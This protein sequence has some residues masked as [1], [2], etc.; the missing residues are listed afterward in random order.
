[1]R[2]G[3]LVAVAE[4]RSGTM[5]VCGMSEEYQGFGNG[6]TDWKYNNTY[7]TCSIEDTSG[8][9]F[10]DGNGV[11]VTLTATSFETPRVYTGAVTYGAGNTTATL[12]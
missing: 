4:F 8:N 10:V 7:A 11:T 9:D 6:S 1:M 12:A 5:R 3:C 2:N